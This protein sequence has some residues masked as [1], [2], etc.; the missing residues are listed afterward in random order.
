MNITNFKKKIG[1]GSYKWYNESC[2]GAKPGDIYV[3]EWKDDVI[4]GCGRW[5]Y[6]DR[7]A[8]KGNF[9]NWKRLDGTNIY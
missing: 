3:G 2:F 7:T 6:S 8:Y 1:K 4:D 9:A 5:S